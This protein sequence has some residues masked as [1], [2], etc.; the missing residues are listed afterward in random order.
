VRALSKVEA[1]RGYPVRLR[2]VVTYA[3]PADNLLFIQEGTDGLY[4]HPSYRDLGVRP[5]D[6]VI[7]EG[8]TAPGGLA[9]IVVEPRLVRLGGTRLPEPRPSSASI[10]TTGADDC[11]R[12]ELSGIVRAVRFVGGGAE[13]SLFAEG[14]RVQVVVPLGSAS[15]GVLPAVGSRLRV[16]GVGGTRFDWHGQFLGTSVFVAGPGDLVVVDPPPPSSFEEPTRAIRDALRGGSDAKWGRR[17]R[18]SGVVLLH[19]PGRRLY[20]RDETG[21]VTVETAQREPLEPGDRVDAVGFPAA[22]GSGPHLEDALLRPAGH[23]KAPAPVAVQAGQVMAGTLTAELVR[24]EAPLLSSTRGEGGTTL[25]LQLADG[26]LEA[27]GDGDLPAELSLEP[28]SLLAAQGIL[29]AHRDP[30]AEPILRLVLR[31]PSDVS[32][33]RSPPWWTPARAGWAVGALAAGLLVAFGWLS[34]LHREVRKQTAAVRESEE[35][36]R[37]LA[38]NASDIIV[39][40]NP[41]LRCTYASPSAARQ[42]AY[43]VEELLHMPLDQLLTR[44]SFAVALSALQAAAPGDG[45][46]SATGAMTLELEVVCKDGARRW[47]EVRLSLLRERSGPVQGFLAVARDITARRQTQRELARLATAVGQAAEAVI[48]TDL[49]GVILYV[50]PAFE[51]ITGYSAAEAVGQTPRLLKSGL[52]DRAFYAALWSTIRSGR[53]WEGRFTNRRKDG[54]LFVEDASI[55][56]IREDE[57]GRLIGYVA[58]KRDVTRQV[59]LESHL[60]QNQ[61]ME[62][63]GRLAAGVAHDFNNMLAAILGLADVAVR[64]VGADQGLLPLLTG[65]RDAALRAAELTRQILTFSRQSPTELRPVEL[66]PVVKEAVRLVRNLLAANVEIRESLESRAVVAADPTQIHQVVLNLGMNGGLAMREG[67][68]VLD[69]TL[70]DAELDE[71][72]ASAHP[73]IRPGRFLCLTV[74]DFGSGM[75][76]D[77]LERAF[78]PFFTTRPQGEGTGMGLA[79]VHGIVHRHGG[80]V[81]AES[82]PGRGSTFRV[83]L[84]LATSPTAIADVAEPSLPRGTE[85]ILLVDDEAVVAT[86][87]ERM[88]AELGYAVTTFTRPGAALECFRAAPLAF[89]LAL[90]DLAMPDLGGDRLARAILRLRPIPIVLV[91][92]SAERLSAAQAEEIGVAALV[93]KPL[94]LRGLAEA[95]RRALDLR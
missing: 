79:V 94:S 72:F 31:S 6:S 67:G 65:I 8:F 50:N 39:T 17:L 30:G 83:Y 53:T 86:A 73:P 23:G 49:D 71:A 85:R 48:L 93:L 29:L 44:E 26:V 43:S 33:I 18:V 52:Q 95:V 91:T 35:R 59:Q 82:E 36:Y 16:R 9:P 74:R 90:L 69:V 77:V 64:R 61:K 81:T 15:G 78:E 2:A 1:E 4:V 89:D 51:R 20:L 40:L 60:A 84:P 5:G 56:P 54:G 10:L 58:L 55:S 63:V 45:T 19:Q 32:V 47:Y 87:A 3:D 70:T 34:T 38:E 7:V 28:G 62:A 76:P 37:L 88:L 27:R 24:I 21:T 14:H 22:G 92:G 42:T 13:V 25:Q 57:G 80:I 41:Q 75:T 46:T 66:G 68:G 12:I 11:R